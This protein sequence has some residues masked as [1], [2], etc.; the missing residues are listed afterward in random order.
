LLPVERHHFPLGS[1]SVRRS[2]VVAGRSG[3]DCSFVPVLKHGYWLKHATGKS[4][5]T[6]IRNPTVRLCFLLVV[7]VQAFVAVLFALALN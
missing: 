1:K 5:A 6:T 7:A 3:I 4:F 2:E